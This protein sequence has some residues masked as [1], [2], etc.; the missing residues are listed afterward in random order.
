MSVATKHFIDFYEIENPAERLL[1]AL[2]DSVA[3]ES[4]LLPVP[5]SQWPEDGSAPFD[6]IASTW[7]WPDMAGPI[8]KEQV[9]SQIGLAIDHIVKLLSER[10]EVVLYPM[11]TEARPMHGVG[12]WSYSTRIPAACDVRLVVE[13][14]GLETGVFGLQFSLTTLVFKNA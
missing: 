3:F 14:K 5:T 9:E 7:Q 12:T 4:R 11:T 10:D 6:V 2:A 1:K 13:Y 8:T